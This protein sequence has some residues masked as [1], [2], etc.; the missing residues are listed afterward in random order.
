[1]DQPRDLTGFD[2]TLFDVPTKDRCA[3][4][5][6]PEQLPELLERSALTLC[7]ERSLRKGF[8][9]SFTGVTGESASTVSRSP[10]S[11]TAC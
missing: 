6:F 8:L 10:A 5:P 11:I 2:L 1:M 3:P 7:L 9:I 4:A